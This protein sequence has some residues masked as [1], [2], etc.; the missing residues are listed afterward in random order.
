MVGWAKFHD[1]LGHIA[2]FA[3]KAKYNQRKVKT[4]ASKV[5]AADVPWSRR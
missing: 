5:K 4:D 3:S 2:N 1:S